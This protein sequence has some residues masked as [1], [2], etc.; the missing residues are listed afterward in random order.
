[1][2]ARFDPKAAA[3]AIAKA[4]RTGAKLGVLADSALP[5]DAAEGSSAQAHLQLAL[6]DEVVGWKLA[7]TSV[8]GQR[9]IGVDGPLPGRLFARRV[10]G[11]GAEV[12]MDGNGMLAAECEFVFKLRRDLAA[13]DAPYTEAEVLDAVGALHPGLELPDSRFTDFASA[14]APQLLADNACTHWMVIGAAAPDKWR[15]LNLAAH[16]TQLKRNGE[17]VTQG[18]GEDVLGS[19]LTALTWLANQHASLGCGLQNG[20]F[21]TTGVTGDPSPCQAGDRLVADLG[22][23]GSVSVALCR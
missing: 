19:P 20:Q 4:W 15:S 16:R 11:D 14:G 22:D 8:R 17:V 23:L 18:T 13:R 1:M 9:H 2:T 12:S 5:G 21:V 3:E 7:A 10:V 6:G